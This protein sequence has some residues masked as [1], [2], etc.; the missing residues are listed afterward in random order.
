MSNQ[1]LDGFASGEGL[2]T[3][4]VIEDTDPERAERMQSV[5]GIRS[6]VILFCGFWVFI[7]ILNYIFRAAPARPAWPEETVGYDDLYSRSA[8][9]TAPTR[10]K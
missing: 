2:L 1:R 3:K 6:V 7:I 5:A 8:D 10:A 9:A 4:T